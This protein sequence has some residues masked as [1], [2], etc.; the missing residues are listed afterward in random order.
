MGS[1]EWRRKARIFSPFRIPHSAFPIPHSAF[2]TYNPT[3]PGIFQLSY[4]PCKNGPL[5][6]SQTATSTIRKLEIPFKL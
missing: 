5:K 3:C 6:Q 2:P 1:G 4:R